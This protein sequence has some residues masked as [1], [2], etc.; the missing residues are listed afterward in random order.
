[1]RRIIASD[2]P[3]LSQYSI[4]VQ[5][6]LYDESR[7]PSRDLGLSS[8]DEIDDWGAAKKSTTFGGGFDMRDRGEKGE[9]RGLF[10]SQ[11]RAD[12]LDSWVSNKS[13]VPS[14]GARRFDSEDRWGKKEITGTGGAF[15]SLRERRGGIGGGGDLDN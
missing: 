10:D 6:Q 12:E 14:T 13:F 4:F 2:E 11:S 3:I 7:R 5:F 8:A 15:D 9:R 1:M